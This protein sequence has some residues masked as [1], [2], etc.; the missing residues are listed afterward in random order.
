[1]SAQRVFCDPVHIRCWTNRRWLSECEMWTVSFTVCT[2]VPNCCKGYQPLAWN[3]DFRVSGDQD[4]T[5]DRDADLHQWL[6]WTG[7]PPA[8]FQAWGVTML[9]PAIP[10]IVIECP[11][12]FI[13]FFCSS[14][15][16]AQVRP[17]HPIL[18]VHALKHVFGCKEVPFGG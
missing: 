13:Y 10:N 12:L 11:F 15:S 1:M 16:S 8:N 14:C 3:A 17:N 6:R 2:V 5:S 7:T 18:T 9:P 4:P